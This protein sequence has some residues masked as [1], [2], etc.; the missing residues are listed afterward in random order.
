MNTSL[1]A[2]ALPQSQECSL[3]RSELSVAAVIHSA[4]T[5]PSSWDRHE[6]ET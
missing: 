2:H 1:H 5:A 6:Q 4:R 3:A